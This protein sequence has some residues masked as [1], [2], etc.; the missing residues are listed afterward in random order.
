MSVP[1]LVRRAGELVSDLLFPQRCISC[2][3]EGRLICHNCM[4]KLP[5]ITAPVY[6][7]C[8]RSQPGDATRP[9]YSPGEM[10][11]DGICSPFRFDGAIREAVH[12][13]K[14]RNVRALA[15]PLAN[16][17][18]DYLV[19]N[20]L[21]A[22]V[23]VPVALHRQR[24]RERGYNQSGLLAR[25]LGRLAGLP[26][27]EGCLVRQRYTA[28]QARTSNVAERQQNMVSAF[29]CRDDCLRGKHVLLIDDVCTSGA[30]LDSCAAALKLGGAASVWG[31]TLA[32]EE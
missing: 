20:P 17:L 1:L 9:T 2:G 6:D 31:L 29:T 19:R 14:Y 18:Y 21:P 4:G 10:T 22:D 11:I 23:L 7:A 8:D 28:A 15:R 3:K 24:L 5:R 25:E 30:T 26:V 13:L 12:Q 16:L 27:V 32:R